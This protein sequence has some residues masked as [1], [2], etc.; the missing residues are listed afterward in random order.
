MKKNIT[1]SE[2]RFWENF[3]LPQPRQQIRQTVSGKDYPPVSYAPRAN[4]VADRKHGSRCYRRA[5]L[6]SASWTPDPPI[7]AVS[8][9]CRNLEALFCPCFKVCACKFVKLTPL[10]L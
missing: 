6:I 2:R 5:V 1:L 8:N 3:S 10:K 4:N 7:V 9:L